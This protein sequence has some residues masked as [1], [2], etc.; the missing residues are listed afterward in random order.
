MLSNVILGRSTWSGFGGVILLSPERSARYIKSQI[1][2]NTATDRLWLTEELELRNKNS[3]AESL[4]EFWAMI[5]IYLYR[6]RV[7]VC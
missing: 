7:D 6:I 2:A 3:M 4:K 5:M 1:S